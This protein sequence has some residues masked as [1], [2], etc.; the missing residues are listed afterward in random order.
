MGNKIII[1]ELDTGKIEILDR[2]FVYLRVGY[3]QYRDTRQVICVPKSWILA[4]YLEILDRY[5]V[6]K[7]WI[8]AK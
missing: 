1:L 5:F 3:W 4:K 2:Y 6:P 8:L 7:S